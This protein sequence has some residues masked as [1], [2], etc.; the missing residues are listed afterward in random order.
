MSVVIA[1]R[2]AIAL[3][4]GG[5]RA[6]KWAEGPGVEQIYRLPQYLVDRLHDPGE[7]DA[8]LEGALS[9]GG[10]TLPDVATFEGAFELRRLQVNFTHSDAVVETDDVRV[11]TIDFIKLASGSPVTTWDAA[12]LDGLRSRFNTFWT[13]IRPNYGSTV[14]LDRMKIYKL[15]PSV[16]PPQVPVQDADYDLAGSNTGTFTMPP[17]VA[18]SVTEKAGSKR[19]WGRFYLPPP[20]ASTSTLYGRLTTAFSTAIA[21]AADVMYEANKAANTP[22]VVYRRALPVRTQKNGVEIAARAASAWTVDDLQVDDIFDVIRSRR[23]KY[24]TLRTQR[25]IA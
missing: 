8:D 16:F 2:V 18:V 15:G 11:L 4:P 21:D 24:P 6:V 10:A 7:S 25:N 3:A 5:L 9:D 1:F 23:W 12:D 13:T 17:Q 14:K 19:Y 20:V 22:A